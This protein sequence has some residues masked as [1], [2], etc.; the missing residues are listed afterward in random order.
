LIAG[1][2]WLAH[3]QEMDSNQNTGDRTKNEWK[4]KFLDGRSRAAGQD[5]AGWNT[6]RGS[7]AKPETQTQ[8]SG[9]RLDRL[10]RNRDQQART[11]KTTQI[12][13]LNNKRH[14]LPNRD[15]KEQIFH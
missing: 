5:L 13:G 10:K 6:K 4:S 15:L 14:E 1:P 7:S 11:T 8:S 9:Y 3:E 2:W 12:W